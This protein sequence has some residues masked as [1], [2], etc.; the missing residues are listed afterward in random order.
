[1]LLA[2]VVVMAF[3]VLT[4]PGAALGAGAEPGGGV[5]EGQVVAWPFGT[6]PP[7]GVRRVSPLAGAG[8]WMPV[9]RSAFAGQF[10]DLDGT[11]TA[12]AG[13][14]LVFVSADLDTF[15]PPLGQVEPGSFPTA[16]TVR[17]A[18]HAVAL[19]PTTA[20]SLSGVAGSSYGAT[21]Y[22]YTGEWVVAI[23][24]G[25]PVT[26]TASEG[27][28]SQ[29]VDLRDGDQVGVAPVVLYRDSAGPLGLDVQPSLAATLGVSTMSGRVTF[30]VTVKDAVLSFFRLDSPV[31][32]TGLG[33]GDAFLWA[34]VSVGKGEGRA[35]QYYFDPVDPPTAAT[36]GVP[37][38]GSLAAAFGPTFQGADENWPGSTGSW[39]Q[40]RS[41][42]RR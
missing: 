25:A 40:R 39:C 1:V 24:D 32:S 37:G 12:G 38:R 29:S 42:R 19:T 23:P 31:P 14:E 27:G 20:G 28:F 16:L 34:S 35:G 7:A 41:R 13:D 3:A 33:S 5:G 9:I 2:I 22:E 4:V 6:S 18:G 36:L 8:F 26:L 17:F 15:D 10:S 21:G 11:Y 30:P